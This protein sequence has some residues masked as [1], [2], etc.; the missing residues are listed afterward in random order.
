MKETFE[1]DLPDNIA[2]EPRKEITTR[3]MKAA[4]AVAISLGVVGLTPDFT[5]RRD[6]LVKEAEQVKQITSPEELEAATKVWKHVSSFRIEMRKEEDAFKRPLNDAKTQLMAMV[7][8]A[9]SPAE[10]AE[11]RLSDMINGYARERAQEEEK[12][13]REEAARMK[14]IEDDRI[15]AEQEAARMKKEKE[16]A[17]ERARKAQE[18]AEAAKTPAAKAKAEE[19]ARKAQETTD[20]LEEER[21]AKELETPAPEP[22]PIAAPV[23]QNPKGLSTKRELDYRIAGKNQFEKAKNIAALAV[24]YP[25]LFSLT[26]EKVQGE[27]RPTGL[28]LLRANILD[29]LNGRAPEFPQPPIGIET[30]ESFTSRIR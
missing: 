14:K 21:L 29:R 8:E 12:R 11:K 6:K 3:A 10:K 20:A 26:T 7:N 25:D 23:A 13:Q 9:M 17:E 2:A 1:L 30:F 15:K 22:M 19:A 5:E 16:D 18:A 28:R 4:N 27:D 24:Q